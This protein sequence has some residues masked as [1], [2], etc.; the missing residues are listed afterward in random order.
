MLIL[1]L[2]GYLNGFVTARYLKFYGTNDWNFSAIVSALT[3]PLYYTS[4]C[5]F[6]VFFAWLTN[7]VQR[8]NAMESLMRAFAWYALNGVLCFA[9]AY[10]GFLKKSQS[11]P[12]EVSKVKRPIPPQP[13]Y[14]NILVVA[15]AFGLLQFVSMYAEFSYL[16]NSIFRNQIYAMFGF[17]FINFILLVAV[18]A[19]LSIL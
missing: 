1:A 8:F 11:L 9:G 18:I 2:F 15:P 12:C 16:F 14:M 13:H 19:L 6:E 5:I 17:L 4:A 7:S 10:H 3:L